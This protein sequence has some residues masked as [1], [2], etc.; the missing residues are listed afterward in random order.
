MAPA[1]CAVVAEAQNGLEAIAALRKWRP[2]LLLLD[3]AMP[4]AGGAEVLVEARR[5]SPETKVVILTGVSAAGKIRELWGLGVDGLFPKNGATDEMLAAI[6]AILG[7]RRVVAET[8]KSVAQSDA[9][10]RLTDRERQ[11]LHLIIGGAG[12]K[13]IA[14]RLGVSPKTV[15]RHRTTLMS[16]LDVH[17]VAELIAYALRE[18]LIDPAEG[19]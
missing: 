16:K 3:V 6:P 8:L 18:R 11:V 5:W 17:S 10:S 4:L 12:N 13:E 2:D 14:E 1:G 19:L 9:P 15:D 7:G